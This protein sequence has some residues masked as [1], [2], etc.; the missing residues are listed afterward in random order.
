MSS[1]CSPSDKQFYNRNITIRKAIR[2]MDFN[3][4]EQYF[5]NKEKARPKSNINI[6]VVG[7]SNAGKSSLLK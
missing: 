4:N 1:Q 3:M 5:N 2:E 7:P 6:L